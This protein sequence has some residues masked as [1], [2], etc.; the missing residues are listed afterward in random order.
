[1]IRNPLVFNLLVICV[2]YG[3]VVSYRVPILRYLLSVN[4]S[5]SVQFTK[6]NVIGPLT[7]VISILECINILSNFV[8]NV[9]VSFSFT[10]VSYIM[11]ITKQSSF[12]AIIP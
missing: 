4:I 8:T 6:R 12:T 2:F 1:M 9:N 7:E 5:Q 11:E 10:H 3:I